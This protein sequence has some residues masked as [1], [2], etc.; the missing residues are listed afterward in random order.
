MTQQGRAQL[1]GHLISRL[2][3]SK[4]S[5]A[6]LCFPLLAPPVVPPKV[7]QDL[8]SIA[9]QRSAQSAY[10]APYLHH[11]AWGISIPNALRNFEEAIEQEQGPV[12]P[13]LASTTAWH[14]CSDLA[15]SD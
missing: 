12:L 2:V 10:P 7:F 15:L 9:H 6:Q 13:M 5:D 4:A 3:A 14:A 1:G 8:R 11:C